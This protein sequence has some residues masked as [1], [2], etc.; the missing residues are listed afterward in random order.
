MHLG[1]LP[2]DDLTILQGIGPARQQWLRASFGVRTFADLA[3]LSPAAIEQ[4][5]KEDGQI[6]R[7]LLIEHKADRVGSRVD[8]GAH[9]V[10]VGHAADLDESTHAAR[11]AAS[12][13]AISFAGSVA[14]I[15]AVPTSAIR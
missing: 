7:R 12:M 9:G 4:R 11:P 3:A 14:R 10:L 5:L 15:S 2:H 13:S 1:E 6:A 8:R